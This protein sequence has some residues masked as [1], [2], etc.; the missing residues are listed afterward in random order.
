MPFA[1]TQND[2][3]IV[4]KVKMTY[5]PP[6]PVDKW[7]DSL[8]SEAT[9]PQVSMF[10]GFGGI[11]LITIDEV[12]VGKQSEIPIQFPPRVKSKNKTSNWVIKDKASYEPEAVF[13]GSDA[14]KL[15]VELKYLVTGGAWGISTI[16][17]SIHTIMGYFYRT[18]QDGKSGAP[19]VKV[20]LYEICPEKPTVSTWRLDDANIIYS[21]EIV[22]QDGLS[23][24]QLSTATLSLSM[25]TQIG[26]TQGGA[27][28][29]LSLAADFPKKEWY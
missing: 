9:V 24:P 26:D 17:K 29:P 13:K 21:D 10:G 27:K 12:P 18:V 14:A 4:K 19:L 16:S 5:T 6:A 23:Y 3:T 7:F 2:L 15:T 28:Q 1:Y 20:I 11:P 25:L 8:S 22:H